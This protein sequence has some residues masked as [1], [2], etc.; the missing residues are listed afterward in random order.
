MSVNVLKPLPIEA[1][2]LKS[3]RA[4]LIVIFV[5]PVRHGWP[6]W[7]CTKPNMMFWMSKITQNYQNSNK[8][9][10]SVIDVKSKSF[11]NNCQAPPNSSARTK[12]YD[13]LLPPSP[14]HYCRSR[15]FLPFLWLPI[16]IALWQFVARPQRL[17][18]IRISSAIDGT[19]WVI[20]CSGRSLS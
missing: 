6:E 19:A 15:H 10:S 3:Y 9:D 16:S 12:N 13:H 17:Q 20:S 14:S 1:D 5:F 11:L 4:S 2:V 7:C 8:H 18:I